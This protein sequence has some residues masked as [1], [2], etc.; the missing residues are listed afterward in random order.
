MKY[1]SLSLS[2]PRLFLSTI[3]VLVVGTVIVL[4]FFLIHA[5]Q[6]NH[7]RQTQRI[8]EQYIST[9]K[10]VLK[11]FVHNVVGQLQKDTKGLLKEWD[12]DIKFR[13]RMAQS[14]A[15]GLHASFQERMSPA[16]TQDMIQAGLQDIQD[17]HPQWARYFVIKDTQMHCFHSQGCGEEQSLLEEVQKLPA[18]SDLDHMS[19]T[20]KQGRRGVRIQTESGLAHVV[21]FPPYDW[22]IGV[23]VH[24][25]VVLNQVRKDLLKRLADLRYAGD[26]ALFVIT[27]SGKKL[28]EQGQVLSPPRDDWEQ[29]NSDGVKIVQELVQLARQENGGFLQY[30]WIPRGKEDP[31]QKISYVA[32]FPKWKW[33]IGA[34]IYLDDLEKQI[35]L[36]Q[37]NLTQALRRSMLQIAGVLIGVLLC[38]FLGARWITKK[39]RANIGYLNTSIKE[40]V[41]N[42][43]EW[44][45]ERNFL[46]EELRSIASST[47]IMLK[48]R[49]EAEEAL[50]KEKLYLEKL[51]HR[52]PLCI[53]LVDSQSRIIDVNQKFTELFGY[54]QEESVGQ[55]IDELLTDQSNVDK[56]YA[57]TEHVA[58]GEEIFREDLRRRK[59][60]DMIPVAI[61]GVPFHTPEG[62][63]HVYA[64][65]QDISDKRA[66]ENE[67]LRLSETDD[68]TGIFNRKKFE[69]ELR[70]ELDI[71]HRYQNPS[72][73]VIM[74]IDHFKRVND[75]YG[76][77]VGDEL[78]KEVTALIQGEIRDTDV[79]AR[80]GGEEFILLLRYA[81][82][83]QA[84]TIAQRLRQRIS[85]QEF[86]DGLHITCSFGVSQMQPGD[87][88]A[89]LVQRT[90][91]LLYQAKER[92][93][94]RVENG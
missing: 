79:F 91:E 48:G 54:S 13:A 72:T 18:S 20:K 14:T 1:P 52:A 37:K 15:A 59:D 22:Y 40:A 94:N 28:L 47:N 88:L 74:D 85:Q 75:E 8:R 39:L 62:D 65:Y 12:E 43:S 9:Q 60:G 33:V 6:T 86:C 63:M 2:I 44:L 7:A 51:F 58:R 35:Q 3:V 23:H 21:H 70:T 76:H 83:G 11:S 42:P 87:S 61:Y 81:L 53:A 92:G 80:W 5:Q 73:L 26:P 84:V 45:E 17:R 57:N 32:Q 25:Q 93:R 16:K 82:W 30:T 49:K 89:S 31:K 36:Q 10:Q 4:G 50:S 64:M 90:D 69:N 68:L 67:L 27:F 71:Y 41:Q 24:A 77:P 78:L 19:G 56:A 55:D 66:Y 38:V 34:G 46:F 29:A